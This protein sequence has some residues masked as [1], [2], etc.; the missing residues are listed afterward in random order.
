MDVRVGLLRKLNTKEFMLLNCGVEEDSWESLGLP[1][2][3]ISQSSRKSV[4]NTHWKDWC[5]SWNSQYFGHLMGR[6]DSFEKTLMLGMIEQRRR[7]GWQRMRWLD[8]ITDSMDMSL[9]KV[10]ELTYGQESLA[11]CSPWGHKAMDM[12]ERLNRLHIF[13]LNVPWIIH[14]IPH[15]FSPV[16]PQGLLI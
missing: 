12:T 1:G 11:Y 9:S 5:W 13:M 6:T 16:F 10:R 15:A 3:Q 14:I 2:D 7:R 4:L 8:G